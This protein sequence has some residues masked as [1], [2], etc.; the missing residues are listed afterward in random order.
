MSAFRTSNDPQYIPPHPITTQEFKTEIVIERGELAHLFSQS[1]DDGPRKKYFKPTALRTPY[2][3]AFCVFIMIIFTALQ[4]G[5]AAFS[6]APGLQ[7]LRLQVRSISARDDC[8]PGAD[9]VPEPSQTIDINTT[10]DPI[11]SDDPSASTSAVPDGLPGG[12]PGGD[13]ANCPTVPNP[14]AFV[15]PNGWKYFLGAYLPT[16]VSL[17]VGVWWRCI[18]VRLKEMEPFYQ[19]TKDQGAKATDSLFLSYP[20]T[21]ILFVLFRSSFSKHSL[22]FLGTLNALLVTLCTVLASTTLFIETVGD[23]CNAVDGINEEAA[24]QCQMQLA[25]RPSLAW[26]LSGVLLIIVASTSYIATQTRKRHSGVFVNPT[27]IAGTAALCSDDLAKA[28]RKSLK[29]NKRLY[30]ITS[31]EKVDAHPLIES[32]S[33]SDSSGGPSHE[34]TEA[35]PSETGTHDP[36]SVHSA[37]LIALWLFMVGII[38]MISYYRW[39]S[40]P[41]TGNKLEDFMNSRGQG[42]RVFMTILGM[43][44]KFY[45]GWIEDYVRTAQP[46]IALTSPSGASARHS[47]LVPTPSSPLTALFHRETWRSLLLGAVTLMAVLSE[48]LVIALNTVPFRV[49]TA[50]VAAYSSMYISIGILA[51]MVCTLT[52]VII[53]KKS[54]AKKI[55]KYP[56]CMADV[57][58]LLGDAES[59][60]AMGKLFEGGDTGAGQAVGVRFALQE[61]ML[62]ASSNVCNWCIVRAPDM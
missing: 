2:L 17:M 7:S 33:P 62:G 57:F 20:R 61:V 14:Y 46:F 1:R 45:W 56:E 6:G 43:L 32:V 41:G 52:T 59:R 13:C 21:T 25:M 37:L 18:Y 3:V 12:L 29:K 54:I 19:M 60:S 15:K 22:T 44:V 50:A 42:V 38:F 35:H 58:G 34:A 16:L 55:P 39:V 53:W 30:T 28:S 40:K 9:C 23:T 36:F 31:P 10:P 5:A 24:S 26:F 8:P 49:T 11:F 48:V 47:V 4:I 51:A 27:T